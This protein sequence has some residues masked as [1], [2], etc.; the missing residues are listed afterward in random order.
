MATG[1]EDSGGGARVDD[2]AP[3]VGSSEGCSSGSV[4][5]NAPSGAPGTTASTSGRSA[6]LGSVRLYVFWGYAGWSRCQLMGEIARGSWGLCQ[7]SAGDLA[8]RDPEALWTQ[9][10]HRFIFAPKNELSETYGG[11]DTDAEQR[12]RELRRL[13]LYRE[14]LRRQVRT[15]VSP[16]A[17]VIP[18]GAHAAAGALGSSILQPLAVSPREQDE[19]EETSTE[20]CSEDEGS[21]NSIHGGEAEAC[22]GAEEEEVHGEGME[23]EEA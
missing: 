17:T 13:A 19:E 10:Y 18:A 21:D 16:S 20:S 1:C 14:F 23:E 12:R 6:A 4:R 5:A 8:A 15:A 9:I 3:K 22:S 2:L 7:A 11:Q